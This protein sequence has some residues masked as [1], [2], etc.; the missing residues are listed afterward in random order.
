MEAVAVVTEAFLSSLRKQR[1]RVAVKASVRGSVPRLL[2]I[3][4]L[5]PRDVAGTH[6]CLHA[7]ARACKGKQGANA[8]L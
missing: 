1:L 2:C 5:E 6:S 3:I 8:H 4:R 7:C